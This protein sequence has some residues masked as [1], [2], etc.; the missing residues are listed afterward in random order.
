[1][2]MMMMT[3]ALPR[4]DKNKEVMQREQRGRRPIKVLASL[5][6]GATVKMVMMAMIVMMVTMTIMFVMVMTTR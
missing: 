4:S 2:M 5:D 1:M 3:M 6:G